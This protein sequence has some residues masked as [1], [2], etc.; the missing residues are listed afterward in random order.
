MVAMWLA[1]VHDVG[2]VSP[3]F[4]VQVPGLAD[5]MRKRGLIADPLLQRDPQRSAVRHELVGH[6]AFREWLAAELGFG[7]RETAEQFAV[8]VGGHHGTPPDKT[9]LGQVRKRPDLAGTGA[10]ADARA[11]VLEWAAEL[12]GG[13]DALKGRAGTSLDR[14][15]EALLTAIVIMADWIASNSDLFPLDP[16]HTSYEPPRGPD[17]ARTAYRTT[18]GWLRLALPDRWL[19]QSVET[20][21]TAFIARFG[22]EPRPVQL[23]AVEAAA[24]QP[25]PGLVVIEAPMG[26]GKTEAALLT[27]EVLADRSGAAGCF[28]ALPTRATTD[29]MFPRVLDWMRALPGL[30]A[31]VSVMLAHGT[32]S[33]NDCY[34]GLVDKGWS[35]DIGDDCAHVGV[36]HRWLRGRNKVQL[37]QF[38]VG[39]VDQV[40]F[41]ALKS[42]HLVLRH[43]ALAGK[44]VIIGEVHAYDVF[45]SRYLDRALHWLGAYGTP[46][47]L[48]SATLPVARRTELI[49]AYESG[50]GAEPTL[51]ASAVEYPLVSASG[52]AP[53]VVPAS[54]TPRSVAVERVDEQDDLVVLLRERLARGGCAVIVRNTVRRVQETA[55]RLVTEFGEEQVTINHA[56]F[57][58]C[59]RA[60]L[61]GDLL[62]MFG[63]RARGGGPPPRRIS[64]SGGMSSPR[65][66]GWSRF[67]PVR[68]P[69]PDVVPPRAGVVPGRCRRP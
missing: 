30:N 24:A 40:L 31:D 21:R 7:R 63:P 2:K 48:L 67:A 6:V 51:R 46:V 27:A 20:A 45:M 56:R 59:D 33:L 60:R 47:V 69:D 23:A 58:A 15:A 49:T 44:V 12:C 50:R 34:R 39:T 55:E 8:I 11:A 64:C 19:P 35:H 14:P 53:R 5:R 9:R 61:D 18:D 43:L 3:A 17:P 52:S 26:E 1:A 66:R 22:K 54:G 13:R 42:R 41:A 10:W 36:A 38:V 68:C 28:V 25:E 32:A 4:A 62:R 16:L 65:S 29:A 57:L 37:A